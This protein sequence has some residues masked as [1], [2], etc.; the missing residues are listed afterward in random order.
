MY[1]V[2]WNE[3]ESLAIDL[4]KKIKR[5]NKSFDIIIGVNRGGLLLARLLSS[6][7]ELPMGV[8]DAKYS[9]NKYIVDNFVSSIYEIEGNILLVDDVF[10]NNSKEII[11]LLKKK[12]NAKTVLLACVFYKQNKDT[13]KPDFFIDKVESIIK[14]IFPYQEKSINQKFK[15]S[16]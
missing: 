15:Q 12:Y 16:L 2:S 10:E 4:A 3:F 7:L 1:L 13:F 6:M 8:I 11:S 9:G 5:S 14:I